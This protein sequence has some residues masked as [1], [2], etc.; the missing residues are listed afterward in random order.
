MREQ[1]AKDFWS[2]YL[3]LIL[4]KG[5]ETT[6][7]NPFEEFRD[8]VA[9]GGYESVSDEEYANIYDQVEELS[10]F[11]QQRPKD[12]VAHIVIEA[13]SRTHLYEDEIQDIAGILAEASERTNYTQQMLQEMGAEEAEK[14]MADRKK[15]K[16]PPVP[17]DYPEKE[18]IEAEYGFEGVYEETPFDDTDYS[19]TPKLIYQYLGEHV[20]GQEEAKRGAAGDCTGKTVG[21]CDSLSGAA[22]ASGMGTQKDDSEGCG[23]LSHYAGTESLPE[24][25]AVKKKRGCQEKILDTCFCVC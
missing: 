17:P 4:R 11:W 9:K 8:S 13:L 25:P 18:W 16:L 23:K 3:K 21:K 1:Q 2:A 22:K 15:A 5:Q 14:R 19:W 24:K 10:V 20:Y 12:S 6:I 7:V